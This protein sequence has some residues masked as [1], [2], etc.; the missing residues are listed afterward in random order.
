LIRAQARKKMRSSGK[1]ITL[2]GGGFP[3]RRTESRRLTALLGKAERKK[4]NEIM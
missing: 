4:R 3:M 1:L 2:G